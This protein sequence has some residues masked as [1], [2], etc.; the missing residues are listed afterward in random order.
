MNYLEAGRGL[1][2]ACLLNYLMFYKYKP[3][4]CSV[5]DILASHLWETMRKVPREWQWNKYKIYIWNKST[6]ECVAGTTLTRW[7]LAS[8]I[9]WLFAKKWTNSIKLTKEFLWEISRS[10]HVYWDR[11]MY[12]CRV[13]DKEWEMIFILKWYTKFTNTF[14]RDYNKWWRYFPTAVKIEF[15]SPIWEDLTYNKEDND[16]GTNK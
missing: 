6:S 3:M 11:Y 8:Y 15:T 14:W 16:K 13:Y 7:W 9:N 1:R 2:A 12:T 10:G 5:I 4:R